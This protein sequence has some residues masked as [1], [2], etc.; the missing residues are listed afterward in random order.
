[1]T[2]TP[3]G[4]DITNPDSRAMPVEFHGEW[5]RDL[6]DCGADTSATRTVISNDGIVIGQNAQ[7]VVAV[8]FINGERTVL[9]SR[10]VLSAAQIAVVTSPAGLDRDEYSLFYFGVS[11]D[12]QWLVNLESMDWV[13]RR[14]Q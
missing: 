5:V 1:M 9:E 6:A 3:F 13:L 4:E 8:R 11:E 2:D 12:G 14:C 7:R 10:L